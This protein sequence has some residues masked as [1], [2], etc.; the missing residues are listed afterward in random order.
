MNEFVE[1]AQQLAWITASFRL[2]R[3]GQTS[4]SEVLL[5]HSGNMIF[6]IDLLDLEIIPIKDST[7]WLPLFA[8]SIVAR[9]F[10]TPA[11]NGEKGI[12]LPFSIM[13][14]L[15]N[16]MYPVVHGEGLYLR[17]F[18]NLLF[19]TSL[20]PE[21]KS[22]QWHLVSSP[23]PRMRLPSGT[24]P[25]ESTECQWLKFTDLERLASASRTFLG[26]CRA[27][28]VHLGT[29]TSKQDYI[30]VTDS[31]AD[32][33]RPAPGVNPKSVT[34][35]TSGLG[36]FGFQLNVDISLPKCRYTNTEAGS[37]L[38]LI[39]DAKETPMVV[40]DNA[41][42]RERGWLVPILSVV[43]HMVHIWARDKNDL[44]AIPPFADLHWDSGQASSAA[45]KKHGRV[46]IRRLPNDKK[47]Y[48]YDLVERLL[49]TSYKLAEK[50]AIAKYEP[51]RTV[52][53][54]K[55]K[56]YGW[57][58]M[59]VAKGH[60]FV[61]RKQVDMSEDW[62]ILGA[63]LLVLFCKN[64]GEIIRPAS[65]VKICRWGNL[66]YFGQ[67][68]LTAT[69]KTLQILSE[70]RS[71]RDANGTSLRLADRAYWPPS[72]DEQF[73][74]CAQ[75]LDNSHGQRTTCLKWPQQIVH[76]EPEHGKACPQIPLQGAVS[77]G[78]R[79]SQEN[80]MR[81]VQ[82]RTQLQSIHSDVQI[83]EVDPQANDRPIKF[84]DT[85]EQP[86]KE[87]IATKGAAIPSQDQP[88]NSITLSRSQHTNGEHE[89]PMSSRPSIEP[90]NSASEPVV[91]KKRP[92]QLVNIITS[93]FIRRTT[94]RKFQR[95][96]KHRAK[97]SAS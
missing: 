11:R 25:V 7:C 29:E 85:A 52:N 57:E 76:K 1:V 16:I 19:P 65:H 12:E 72:G 41:K 55:P 63:D 14:G 9:G 13:T 51:G 37:Y 93:K 30:E 22:V 86:L 20:S 66:P 8:N 78:K 59:A 64:L 38:D 31:G 39:D 97:E 18:S 45:I 61:N 94:W 88:L 32:D 68:Y 2:P 82:G 70:Q 21:M 89:T 75:C 74:D 73:E 79:K 77:F 36:I 35:G 5:E 96:R 4:Y 62:K 81:T 34:T 3:Y 67:N 90:Q 47:Y 24:L 91:K 28:E 42:E 71:G 58:L 83:D 80:R 27:V 23:K 10:P 6:N 69:V 15:A 87:A 92:S 40:Y 53:F 43:L 49:I 33:E 46:E 84:P 56:L 44:L 48:L 50:Q 17:G 95:V 54:E 26:Y 60:R